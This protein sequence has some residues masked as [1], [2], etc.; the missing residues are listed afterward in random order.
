MVI[1]GIH[2]L[3]IVLIKALY[4]TKRTHDGTTTRES[5]QGAVRW[6]VISRVT[7][8][9]QCLGFLV[10]WSM[11][12]ESFRLVKREITLRGIA[13][14]GIRSSFHVISWK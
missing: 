7:N 13:P 14:L 1:F 2:K 12:T 4:I 5:S 10:K 8:Q 11:G 9:L 3:V 6:S